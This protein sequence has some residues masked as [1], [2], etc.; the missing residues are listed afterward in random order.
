M[1]LTRHDVAGVG[2]VHAIFAST[3]PDDAKT[4]HVYIAGDGVPSTAAR[5]DPPDP[6]PAADPTFGLMA[7]DPAPRILLGRPCQHVPGDCDP[8]HFTLGRY[9]DAV[10]TS[11]AVALREFLHESALSE[12]VRI[13]LIGFSGG[14]T[15]AALLAEHLPEATALVTLAAN[16][17]TDAWAALH[18]TPRLI[19]SLNPSERPP[20]GRALHQLHLRGDRDENV[21][22]ELGRAW[23]ERQP[24]ARLQ[25]E[26]GFDHTC[27]WERIWPGVLDDWLQHRSALE[28]QAPAEVEGVR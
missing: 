13:V 17:D 11:M 21:P 26:R 1:G 25:I 6:T 20:L 24:D 7:K 10:V 2:F 27:C 12:D 18:G 28:A 3:I 9:G 16:L 4:L 19:Y 5:Y 22:A 15:I 23:I 14:G 8:L